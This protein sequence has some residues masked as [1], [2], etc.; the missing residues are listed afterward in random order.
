MY[1]IIPTTLVCIPFLYCHPYFTLNFIQLFFMLVKIVYSQV[2]LFSNCYSPTR[3]WYCQSFCKLPKF[4]K[5]KIIEYRQ[6]VYILVTV[7]LLL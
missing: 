2:V 3:K 5:S 6:S 4:N 1:L 7:K